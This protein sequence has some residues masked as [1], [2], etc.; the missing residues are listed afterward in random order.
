MTVL[1]FDQEVKKNLNASLT[2]S[3][4]QEMFEK[5]QVGSTRY[6]PN[7]K[8]KSLVLKIKHVSPTQKETDMFKNIYTDI[9]NNIFS[10]FS[11]GVDIDK[12]YYDSERTKIINIMCDILD[13]KSPYENILPTWSA[14]RRKKHALE[15][16]HTKVYRGRMMVIEFSKIYN[17]KKPKVDRPKC[18]LIHL[19]YTGNIENEYIKC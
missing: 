10:R 5:Y 9:I 14:I 2:E 16:D 7:V 11:K 3:L 13:K 15:D 8:T 18:L 12:D 17:I 19:H 4:V 1:A 6:G